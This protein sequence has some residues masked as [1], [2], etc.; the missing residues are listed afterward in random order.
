MS[1]FNTEQPDDQVGVTLKNAVSFFLP[2]SELKRASRQRFVQFFDAQTAPA[3]YGFLHRWR[4]QLRARPWR[5]AGAVTIALVAVGA[6]ASIALWPSQLTY[7][8]VQAA[9]Q[10]VDWI[11]LKFEDGR[12]KWVSPRHGIRAERRG[13]GGLMLLDYQRGIHQSVFR[14][15]ESVYEEQ[16]A[17]RLSQPTDA[18]EAIVGPVTQRKGKF[19]VRSDVEFEGGRVLIRFDTFLTDALNETFLVEQ[20]WADPLTRLPLRIRQRVSMYESGRIDQSLEFVTALYDFPDDGP[21]DVFAMGAPKELPVER[22]NREAPKVVEAEVLNVFNSIGEAASRF[23][24]H[25]RCVTWGTPGQNVSLL[26]WS[27][28]PKVRSNDKGQSWLDFTG[29]KI[30][31]ENYFN[32]DATSD[33]DA[34]RHHLPPTTEARDVLKWAKSQSPVSLDLRDGILNYAQ[35]GPFPPMFA[36]ADKINVRIDREIRPLFSSNYWPSQLFWPSADSNG[37]GFEILKGAANAG[38]GI[39]QLRSDSELTRVEY[40]ID[41]QRDF[42]CVER[43]QWRRRDAEWIVATRTELSDFVQLKTGQWVPRKIHE[44]RGGDPEKNIQ[45]SSFT[46]L[47]DIEAL[48]PA[49]FAKELFDGKRLMDLARQRGGVIQTY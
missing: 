37:A 24:E 41:P 48:E 20:L 19:E 12:E 21:F 45:S 9:V 39:V 34:A 49:E 29:V 5:L 40:R 44:Y 46:Y 4:R 17:P 1:K 11:H 18:W 15:A 42:I 8:Q 38:D 2:D 35:S 3:E 23:P 27:G 13:D 47:Y 43:T 31:Q 16:F 14:H 6:I 25:F 10:T 30:R 26:Y 36:D 32:L 33:L 7:A 28:R 22:R